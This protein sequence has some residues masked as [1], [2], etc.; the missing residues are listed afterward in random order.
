MSA[1]NSSED[2][3]NQPAYRNS[4]NCPN[5]C[6]KQVDSKPAT[7]FSGN[8]NMPTSISTK[9][10]RYA[11]LVSVPFTARGSGKVDFITNYAAVNQYFPPP[12]NKF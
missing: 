7:S 11:Q 5:P 3:F 9:A 8:T 1:I 2:M 4:P 12:R 10:F 6:P